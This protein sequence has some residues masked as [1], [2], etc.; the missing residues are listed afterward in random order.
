MNKAG[1]YVIENTV[2]GLIYVGSSRQLRIRKQQHFN[3]LTNNKHGNPY[4]QNAF[5]LYKRENFKFRVLEYVTNVETIFVR[6]Q[7]YIDL[8]KSYDRTKGYNISR[9]AEIPILTGKD[10][11]NFG[12]RFSESHRS[13]IS[14]AL[15]NNN[16]MTGRFGE[17]HHNYGMKHS[18]E[19]REKISE[20]NR[21]RS[22]EAYEA[23][24]IARRKATR[25][26]N[27]MAKRIVQLDKNGNFMAEYDSIMSGQDA[28]GINRKNIS[29]C[30]NGKNKTAGGYKWLFYDE[31]TTLQQKITT[32]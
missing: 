11:P 29:Y 12:K 20:A 26:K 13:K 21:R 25:G 9:N 24:R 7:Y 3:E 19:T 31:Y 15:K 18:M 6:E 30:L 14:E 32:S 8:Y 2:N 17:L 22:P 27:H 4:L 16:Y 23:I 28:T 1:I 5:N 10:N